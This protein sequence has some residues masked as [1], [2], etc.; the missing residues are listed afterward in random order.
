MDR[1]LR[2]RDRG[3]TVLCLPRQPRLP[4]GN[5]TGRGNS[6]ELW[7]LPAPRVP[8]SAAVRCRTAGCLP[9]S[10]AGAMREGQPGQALDA[11]ARQRGGRSALLP[12][13]QE[14]AKVGSKTLVILLLWCAALTVAF[15]GMTGY[16]LIAGDCRKDCKPHSDYRPSEGGTDEANHT[17]Q[18]FTL[19]TPA[20]SQPPHRTDPYKGD[21]TRKLPIAH[22]IEKSAGGT[23]WVEQHLWVERNC[24]HFGT[25]CRFQSEILTFPNLDASRLLCSRREE[26]AG[27]CGHSSAHQRNH[28]PSPWTLF[29]LLLSPSHHA[30]DM[31]S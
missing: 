15:V 10:G 28:P 4:A 8:L 30:E 6:G 12:C 16:L 5:S 11:V 23:R 29:A 27:S 25:G 14:M 26:S 13:H 9:H 31:K 17:R 18:Q 2:I 21:P 19:P 20:G 7:A 3:G 22:I 24:Q 1:R